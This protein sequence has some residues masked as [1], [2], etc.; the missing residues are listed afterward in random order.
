MADA[1]QERYTRKTMRPA[2]LVFFEEQEKP[3][4]YVIFHR[5]TVKGQCGMEVFTTTSLQVEYPFLDPEQCEIFTENGK[6]YFKNLSENVYT[7]VADNAVKPGE[8]VPLQDCTVIRL[9]NERMLTAV[10]FEDYVS[11][12]DWRILNMDDGRH[13]VTILEK[14]KEEE[15]ASLVLSY[16]A[17]HWSMQEI[18]A[19]RALHNGVPVSDKVKIRIND[20]IELGETRFIFEGAGLVYGYPIQTSGL[21][22][23]IDERSVHKALT[24][25]TL[26]KDINLEINPGEMV[27]ILG[28]SGAGKS[29]FVNAVTGYEKAK[30]KITEGDIDFYKDYGMVKHRIGFVPQENLLREED[31]VYDTVKNAADMRL[32]K[33]MSPEEKS[34][35]IAAVLETFGLSGRERELVSKLSGGQKKR[36]SIC[37]E[38][39]ASPSLFILDEPDSGLDG[40]MATELMENLRMIACQ[41]KMVLVITHQPD[42]VADLFDKVIVLAKSSATKVGQLAFYGGIQEARDFFGVDTMENVVK[43][44]N[45]RNE[46]GEGRADEFIKKYKEYSAARGDERAVTFMDKDL[47]DAESFG[48]KAAK[49]ASFEPDGAVQN[50]QYKSRAEQIP[51]YLGKQFRLLFYEKNWKVLPM[52]ALI[53]FLVTYVLGSK[54]FRNMEFTKYGSLAVVCVCIWNGMFNSIQ[55]ICK[56]RSI[57]KREHRAGLHIS[58][59]I[60]AH[61]IYQAVICLIQVIIT[62]VIFRVF[63]MYFPNTGLI[64]GSFTIDLGI[65]MF[66]M[67]Y[68]ADMLALLASCIS[69]TTTTAMTIVPFLLVIQLIFAGSIFPLERPGSKF[70]A[71]FTISNW[72]IIAVNIAADYN[73]QDS[74]A[75]YTAVDAMKDSTDETLVKIHKVMQIPEVKKRIQG[76]TAQKLQ[77]KK[78]EYT[79]PNLLKS[80]GILLLFAAIYVIIGT[81]FL[82]MIDKDKR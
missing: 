37:T 28:G 63:G 50:L 71:N 26:L 48:K 74:I 27:L 55:S 38:F 20:V 67:T 1:T 24:K 14:G 47:D 2:G 66:L 3:R 61:M 70:L 6:W 76:Y 12:R 40:I 11:G 68:A 4:Q 13:E 22:I 8:T 51:I 54:M 46:G 17:G 62:I 31:T 78:F 57:I 45:A 23:Q 53:A 44:I 36:L 65:S 32:P 77:D 72:G 29:T 49:G 59:Y 41:G 39:V 18:H 60:V 75:I 9:V 56:E 16:E 30:A 80:W 58:S 10:F 34:K 21:S 5:A 25:V 19:A 15:G 69:H 52:S 64:T 42:R 7:F 73:S 33:N 43:C 79:K 35:K 82:E 81:L